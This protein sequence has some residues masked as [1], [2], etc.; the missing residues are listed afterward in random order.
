LKVGVFTIPNPWWRVGANVLVGVRIPEE[1]VENPFP[2]GGWLGKGRRRVLPESRK[3]G[4]RCPAWC[5]PQADTGVAIHLSD[6]I[7]AIQSF[8]VF[9]MSGFAEG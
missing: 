8:L 4:S 1:F 6:R 2:R 5:E 3:A 9:R 7:S